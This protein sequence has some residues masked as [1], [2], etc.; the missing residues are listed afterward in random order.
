M[1]TVAIPRLPITLRVMDDPPPGKRPSHPECFRQ[2]PIPG[3][4]RGARVFH[5][6]E[7]G[8]MRTVPSQ[9]YPATF[10]CAAIQV[11]LTDH[12][13]ADQLGLIA[14]TDHSHI[15]EVEEQPV[16]HQPDH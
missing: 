4:P 16:F 6:S 14:T 3:T 5:D 10:A 13:A 12:T 8:A 15:G 7:N 2:V 11:D 9:V 1:P